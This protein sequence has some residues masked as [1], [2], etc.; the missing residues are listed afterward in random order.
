[1]NPEIIQSQIQ[2]K[3]KCPGPYFP[4]D[5]EI[6]HVKTDVN[7]QPYHRFFRG[8]PGSDKPIVW[9]REAGYARIQVHTTPPGPPALI[10]QD[11]GPPC[12]QTPC[13]TVLPCTQKTTVFAGNNNNS[14]VFISP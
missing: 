5:Q 7:E 9:E 6:F 13:S 8:R 10:D 4:P 3:I 14:P 2:D 1:M 12:F 11:G